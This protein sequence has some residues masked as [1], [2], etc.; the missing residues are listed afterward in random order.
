M[1]SIGI[2]ISKGKSTICM[3]SLYGEVIQHPREITH[4]ETD[5]SKLIERIHELKKDNDVRVVMEATGIYHLPVLYRLKEANIFVCI[6]NPLVMKKYVSLELRRAKTDKLDSI[7]IANYGIDHWYRLIDY[8]PTQ[9]IYDELRLLG[10]QYANFMELKICC[11]QNLLLLLERTMPGISKLLRGNYADREDRDKLSDFAKEFWHFDNI[12]KHTEDEFIDNY[13]KWAKEK[14]YHQNKTKAVTIYALACDSI[15]TLSSNTPST[16]MLV[17]ETIEALTNMNSTLYS[18]LS[19]MQ[20]LSSTLP[21]YSTVKEMEGVGSVLAPRLIAE[22]GDIRRFHNGSSLIAYAGLD[23]P[24]YESGGFVATKRHISKRGSPLLRK[25]G[26]EV[27]Q[28]L[29]RI[30]PDS[31]HVYNYMIKKETEGKPKKVAK[32]AALNKFLRIYFARVK[33]CYENLQCDCCS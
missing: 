3:L 8:T 12:S 16:K 1:I 4:N 28:C 23:A 14:G 6:V 19:R 10:R 18:I 20:E 7:K 11:K 9:E 25:T 2:D 29:K 15:P 17:L 21:E 22:I 32:I 31:S 33:E 30:K 26:Y 27:M 24:P 13:C 5:L